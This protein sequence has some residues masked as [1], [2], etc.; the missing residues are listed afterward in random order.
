[1]IQASA[2]VDKFKYA[3]ENR[4]GYI[5]GTAGVMWTQAK[6][7]QKINYMKA[8]FGDNWQKNADAKNNKYYM[9]A[10]YG[11]KWIGHTVADCSGLFVWAFKELGGSIYH[12]SNTIWKRYCSHKGTL[13]KGARSDG[14][15]IQPGTAVFLNRNGS[16]HHI[17]LYVG[18]DTCIEAKGTKA[19]VVT[20]SLSHWDELGELKDIAYDGEEGTVIPVETLRRGSE[21]PEVTELQEMLNAVGYDCGQSDGKYGAKTEAA[22]RAFQSAEG[23]KI[24]GVAG[25]MT[26]ER[27]TAAYEESLIGG[28]PEVPPHSDKVY[29]VL[30]ETTFAALQELRDVFPALAEAIDNAIVPDGGDS[31]E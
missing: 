9:A 18:G 26:R 2:L 24:D 3:L 31:D 13:S 10:L 14:K 28:A 20:S 8:N 16:R 21:G 7:T 29:L 25:P 30:D 27:L 6:Q 15:P 1:M 4:W 23:L 12:G 19:G 17:G 5:Y 22:V 11:S